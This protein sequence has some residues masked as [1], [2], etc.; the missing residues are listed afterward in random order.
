MLNGSVSGMANRAPV[1]LALQPTASLSP[2]HVVAKHTGPAEPHGT[3]IL[4]RLA[5]KRLRR[6][7]V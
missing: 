5:A 2:D 3:T 4:P 7:H 6:S 1:F